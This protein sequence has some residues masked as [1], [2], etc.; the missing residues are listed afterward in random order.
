MTE[1]CCELLLFD[2]CYLVDMLSNH[3]ARCNVKVGR[4]VVPLQVASNCE[5]TLIQNKLHANSCFYSLFSK[6]STG[7][8][9]SIHRNSLKGSFRLLQYCN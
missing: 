7:S 6:K 9:R 5:D 8:P 4:I 3:N 1:V 2:K